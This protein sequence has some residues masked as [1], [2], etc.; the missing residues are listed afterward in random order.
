MQQARYDHSSCQL[1]EYL[2]VFCGEGHGTDSVEKI[3]IDLDNILQISK[4]WELI[5]TKDRCNLPRLQSHFSIALNNE[6]ILIFGGYEYS[7][8][9]VHIFDTQTDECSSHT[10]TSGALTTF[11]SF[12]SGS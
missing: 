1:A 4:E 8:P 5:L 10:I 6:Q 9:K 12:S 7:E 11:F 3:A 2:Y